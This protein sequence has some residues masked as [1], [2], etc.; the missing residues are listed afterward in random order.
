MH[1]DLHKP[2]QE[3]DVTE[4]RGETIMH[5]TH[6]DAHTHTHTLSLSNTH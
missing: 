5:I 2:E 4:V 3:A 1:E 6:T